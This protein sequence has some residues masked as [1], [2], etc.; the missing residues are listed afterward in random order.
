MAV[1]LFVHFSLSANTI[2]MKQ[3]SVRKNFGFALSTLSVT[4]ITLIASIPLTDATP[5][6]RASHVE[7]PPTAQELQQVMATPPT[8]KSIEKPKKTSSTD[9]DQS[10]FKVKPGPPP[11]FTAA[12]LNQRQTTFVSVYY[13]GK[14]LGNVMATFDNQHIQFLQPKKFLRH[15]TNLRDRKHIS[16][17]LHSQLPTHEDKL[18]QGSGSQAFCQVLQPKVAGVIF[19]P[20]QFRTDLFINPMYVNLSQSGTVSLPDSTADFSFM[21]RNNILAAVSDDSSTYTLNNASIIG[22]RNNQA[23]INMDLT[24]TQTKGERE[25]TQFN[26]QQLTAGH[27]SDS[28][29]YEA[30]MLTPDSGDFLVGQ[31]ILGFSVKN[32]GVLPQQ[33]N[34]GTPLIVYLPLP[35]QVSVYRGSH[36]IGVQN[37]PA[38]KQ[39]LDTRNFPNGAYNITLKITNQ[40]GQTRTENRFFV[41]QANVPASGEINYQISLGFLQKQIA[42]YTITD[43][44][45]SFPSFTNRLVFSYT[46]IR[47][48]ANAWALQTTVLSDFD[49]LFASSTLQYYDTY[50]T[51]SPGLMVS[52]RDAFDT[53]ING[54]FNFDRFSANGNFLKI[55]DQR[56][57]QTINNINNDV[58]CCPKMGIFLVMHSNRC[59]FLGCAGS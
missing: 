24:R 43:Q 31:P 40:Y 10:L 55:F 46:G 57:D 15:I 38:G 14:F 17:V 12:A 37:L 5:T 26:F 32:Y 23:V 50:F 35:A 4:V 48:I 1:G 52:N 19:S 30:G 22:Y 20:D 16:T 51:V 2:T 56:S 21:N 33:N 27:Y 54:S 58:R 11:G 49:Q 39:P 36:L 34:T 53:L 47:K 29:L 25:K 18:C 6:L 59:G 42:N 41:K 7:K 13:Q 3:S 44:G 45:L 8:Q 28:R 9:N